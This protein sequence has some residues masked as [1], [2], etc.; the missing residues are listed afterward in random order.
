MTVS[1]KKSGMYDEVNEQA[2]IIGDSGVSDHQSCKG[3]RSK[4]IHFT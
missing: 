2:K 3:F 4:K 1:N